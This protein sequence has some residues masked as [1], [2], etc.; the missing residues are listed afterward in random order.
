MYGR[1][2]VWQGDMHGLH[3]PWQ[4][5]QDMANERAVCILL[6]CIL[7]STCGMYN[8]CSTNLTLFL[9]MCSKGDSTDSTENRK[10]Q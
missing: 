10:C 6:E 1:G 8:K 7:V 4:I 9:Y 2:H 5:L 3:A